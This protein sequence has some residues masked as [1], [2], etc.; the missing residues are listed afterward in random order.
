MFYLRESFQNL[1]SAN[2]DSKNHHS[3]QITIKFSISDNADLSN[4]SWRKTVSLET[5]LFLKYGHMQWNADSGSMGYVTKIDAFYRWW[6]EYKSKSKKFIV[7]VASF[8]VIRTLVSLVEY[9]LLGFLF[10]YFRYVLLH[11]TK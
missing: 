7:Q 8:L 4:S 9:L 1:K 10:Y 5:W 11:V 3:V 6:K 2:I